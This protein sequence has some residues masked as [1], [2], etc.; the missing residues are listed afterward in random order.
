[1]GCSTCDDNKI[2]LS[3]ATGSDGRSVYIAFASDNVGSNFSYTPS[4]TLE[5]VSFVSKI[6]SSVTQAEFT[7]WVK[8]HGEDGTNGT[9]GISVT[10]ATINDEGELVLTMSDAS[11][12]NAGSVTCCDLT[13]RPLTLINGWDSQD[14]TLKTKAEY[15]IDGMGFIHFRGTLNDAAATSATFAQT[16]IT[17]LTQNLFSSI[18]DTSTASSHSSFELNYATAGLKINNYG[19]GGTTYWILDSIPP[20]LVR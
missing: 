6:G 13:W 10:S 14:A 16:A 7:T 15:V 17:G 8:Y 9:N 20:I 12:I 11:T 19:S 2:P 1:M 4:D 18:S 3:L 5:Y